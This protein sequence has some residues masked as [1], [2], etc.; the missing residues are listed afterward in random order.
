MTIKKV[1]IF[2]FCETLVSVQSADRF[3]DFVRN[4]NPS[5]KLNF[6][7]FIRLL[8]TKL[9][10]FRVLNKLLPNNPLHKKLKLYQLKGFSK[11]ILDSFAKKY[12]DDLLKKN[13][14]NEV[15][16]ILLEKKK[17]N[18][19][20]VILSGGYTIYLKYFSNF[21]Q[22]SPKNIIGTDILFTNNGHCTGRIKGLDCMKKNK[23]IKL[24]ENLNISEFDLKNSISFSDSI[25]DLPLLKFVGTGVFVGKFDK[26]WRKE[27]GLKKVIWK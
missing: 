20:I 12:F 24:K 18:Y 27:N 10:F 2:D 25:S 8:L 19:E 17:E 7:E 15:Y 14:I 1:A 3:I 11:S 5:N 23:I 9:M 22:I 13:I 21:F 4:K 16:K 26:K 6:I